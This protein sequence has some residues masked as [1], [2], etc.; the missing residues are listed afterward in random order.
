MTTTETT[1]HTIASTKL[2]TTEWM[3]EKIVDEKRYVGFVE[4]TGQREAIDRKLKKD[5]LFEGMKKFQELIKKG[6]IKPS[7]NVRF[8]FWSKGDFIIKE[9][10]KGYVEIKSIV[11]KYAGD[12]LHIEIP[13]SYR[14][15][16]EE[17]DE[18]TL[19]KDS[20]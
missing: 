11:A 10:K 19:I 2:D 7:E 13:K 8:G 4:V 6:D 18:I 16:F 3:I 17:G 15:L 9:N 14:H 12:R 1:Y 5:Y 20:I